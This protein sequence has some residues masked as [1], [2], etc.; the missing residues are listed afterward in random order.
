MADNFQSSKVTANEL[1]SATK[2]NNFVQAVEDAINSLD[3]TNIAT[4]AAILVAKLLAG[5]NGQVLKTVAGVPTWSTEGAAPTYQTTLPGSPVDG[6]ETILVDSTSAPTYAWRLRYNSTL[7]KW[8]FIGGRP[9][10]AEVVTPETTAST[11][12]AAL[13]TAGPS[14]VLP[15]A[16]DYLIE[17]GFRLSSNTTS[18][19]S[20]MSY[21][22]GATGAVDAD[23]TQAAVGTGGG[24]PNNV[25]T[26]MRPRVKTGLT[27]V[28]L[29][30]KYK[31]AGTAGTNGFADRWMRVTPVLL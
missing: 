8:E 9:A 11:T 1:S 3:N 30:A 13:T 24:T 14:I 15:V 4:G 6:Q 25:A 7:A 22:I 20:I 10:F 23:A 16:G 28:T 31:T 26:A 18:T 2:F 17:I 12:Y 27:A 5:T 21:D 29:T 19:L